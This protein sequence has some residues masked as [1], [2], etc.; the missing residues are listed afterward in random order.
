MNYQNVS[1]V[2]A[3]LLFYSIFSRRFQMT[4][5]NGP[6]LFVLVGLLCGPTVLGLLNPAVTG[7]GLRGLAEIT[8]AVVLFTDAANAN[9]SVLRTYNWLPSRLLLIGL[10]LTLGAGWLFAWWLFDDMPWLEAAILATLLAPTDAALGKAVVTNPAVPA[11]VREGLNVESGLNDGICVPVLLLLLALI[12]PTEQHSGTLSMAVTFF[13]EEIGIGAV[14]GISLALIVSRLMKYAA[15]QGWELPVWHQ[16]AMLGLAVL[17]FALTQSVGGSGFIAAFVCGLVAGQQ[18]GEHRHAYL[19]SN[20]GYSELLSIIVWLIF[21][22]VVIPQ[23][24]GYF[25]PHVWIYSVASLTVLRMVPVLISLLGT[26]L[27]SETKLFIA[28]FGPRG[29]ASIVFAVIIMQEQLMQMHTLVATTIC[30]ILLS[31]VFH[32]LTANPWVKH[33]SECK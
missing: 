24:W 28:W 33:L 8:L 31:V 27:N 17:S 22:A 5:V 16:L 4:L 7:V 15:K 11:P 18:L 30:T 32:G 10:P 26:P 12:A 19:E 9:L 21:G 25:T 23:A 29:L 1:I 14:V 13:V 20:E 6:L 3:F 2:A